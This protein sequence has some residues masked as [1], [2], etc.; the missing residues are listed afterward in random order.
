LFVAVVP[1]LLARQ[2]YNKN[3]EERISNMW[4]T[5][6]N[7]VDRG[8]GATYNPTGFH[9]GMKQDFNVT[10]PALAISGSTMIDGREDSYHFDNPFLRWHKSFENYSAHLHDIDDF[11]LTITDEYERLKKYRPDAKS[12]AGITPIIPRQ[13]NDEALEFYDI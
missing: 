6:K 3:I 5:H 2:A 9:E 12:I 8:L 13:D 7:R 1:T 11:A 4:R 10:I